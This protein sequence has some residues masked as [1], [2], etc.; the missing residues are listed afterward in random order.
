MYKPE[1]YVGRI[2]YDSEEE[3]DVGGSQ[4]HDTAKP[5]M[6]PGNSGSGDLENISDIERR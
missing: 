3:D 2:D 4:G 6:R 5:R 1:P